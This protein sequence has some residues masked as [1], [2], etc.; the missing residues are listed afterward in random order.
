MEPSGPEPDSQQVTNQGAGAADSAKGDSQA[1]INFFSV[2]PLCSLCLY[3]ENWGGA[4][5]RR[6][7]LPAAPGTIPDSFFTILTLLSDPTRG[8]RIASR[9]TRTGTSGR[10]GRP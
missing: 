8:P 4:G 1:G 9:T 7:P 10:S 6:F 5:V 2:K 3:C